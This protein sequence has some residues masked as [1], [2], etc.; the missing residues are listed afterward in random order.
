MKNN[1]YELI[2]CNFDRTFISINRTIVIIIKILSKRKHFIFMIFKLIYQRFNHSKIYKLK[3]LHFYIYKINRF[4]ILK[5]FDYDVCD[6]IKI[7]KIINKKSHIKITILIT[8]MH[9]DF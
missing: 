1:F 7:I 3:N 9:I 4:E 8:K 2:D 5:D 6:V